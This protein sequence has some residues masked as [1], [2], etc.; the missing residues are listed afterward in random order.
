MKDAQIIATTV[1]DANANFKV[2]VSNV[3]S[4]NYIFSVYSEDKNGNRSSMLT[5]PVG[6][7]S[8]AAT[9]I[10][11]IFIAPTI[12]IDK[13]EVKQG[14]N[15]AIFGA[16]V[17]NAEITISVNSEEEFFKKVKTDANGAYLYQFDTSP[18]EK[19]GHVTKS[20]A[21]SGGDISSFSK[22]V[23]FTVGSKTVLSAP[24]KKIEKGDTNNDKR[25]NLVDFSI[26]A[27][28]YRRPDPPASVDLNGDKKI[29]LVD[30]SIMAFYWTG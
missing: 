13:S 5:F 15:I 29:D 12:A 7:S 3:S 19:G 8:G 10:G 24:V 25:V 30:F 16:S 1:A 26:T 20:K 14:E 6:V 9:E 2:S 21:S 22:A 27:Y 23:S 17:G 4:G 11:G 18:L 28:W